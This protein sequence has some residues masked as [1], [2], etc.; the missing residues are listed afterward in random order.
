[1]Y[2]Q[3]II[4]GINIKAEISWFYIKID[5]EKYNVFLDISYSIWEIK[6]SWDK[7]E[8]LWL[9]ELELNIKTFYNLLWT[10]EQYKNLTKI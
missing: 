4:N 8:F 7:Q 1:M 6:L 10:R 2:L 9:D 5:W 3:W